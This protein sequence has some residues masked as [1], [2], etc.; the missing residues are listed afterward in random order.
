[1]KR[2]IITSI[3]LFLI[4]LQPVSAGGPSSTVS[5]TKIH[6]VE[7]LADKITIVGDIAIQMWI[8]SEAREDRSVVMQRKEFTSGA[9]LVR[10]E[11]IPY[12]SRDDIAGV[13]MGNNTTHKM[14]RE[15]FAD[16]YA[17]NWKRNT[18]EAKKMVEG[19][20]GLISF[21]GELI[22]ITGYEIKSIVGWGSLGAK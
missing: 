3:A 17:N 2:F 7:I 10:I 18:E 9:K 8:A 1:M 5:I 15:R 19:G 22:S 4:L 20:A 21:Q 13:G 12:H 14:L 6:S 16:L 11:L